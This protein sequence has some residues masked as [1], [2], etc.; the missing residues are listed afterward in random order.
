VASLDSVLQAAPA[1]LNARDE[2]DLQTPLFH[3]AKA[4]QRR[5]V[6]RLLQAGAVAGAC[7]INGW[8]ARTHALF[9][10]MVDMAAELHAAELR[11][12]HADNAAECTTPRSSVVA[13]RAMPLDVTSFIDKQGPSRARGHE[14][15][16]TATEKSFGHEYLRHTCRALVD[17]LA[18]K[19][20]GR[21]DDPAPTDVAA[22]SD[23]AGCDT[24]TDDTEVDAPAEAKAG[25]TGWRSAQHGLGE[26]LRRCRLVVDV[27]RDSPSSTELSPSPPPHAR[28]ILLPLHQEGENVA[29]DLPANMAKAERLRVNFW[30]VSLFD[31]KA[32]MGRGS[33]GNLDWRDTRDQHAECTCELFDPRLHLVG[34][35]HFRYLLVTPFVSDKVSIREGNTYW[36]ARKQVQLPVWGH[37]G[38]GSAKA[39]RVPDLALHR[40]HV[41]E[42]TVL[43]FVTAAS[44]GAEYVEFDVQLTRDEVPV[45]YHN[46]TLEEVVQYPVAVNQ[47]T[48]GQ[49]EAIKEA[50]IKEKL[51]RQARISQ[52]EADKIGP[53]L[54]ATFA[55][56]GGPL[57][58]MP[59]GKKKVASTGGGA[60]GADSSS[61]G[62]GGSESEAGVTSPLSPSDR[63]VAAAMN[64]AG[65]PRLTRS[66][67]NPDL[68]RI[69]VVDE[70]RDNHRYVR[71][72]MA[73]L[74]KAL[75]EVPGSVGFN[76]EIKYPLLESQQMHSFTPADM[77]TFLD[78]T[79]E[80]VYDCAGSRNIVFSSFH[81]DIC[82]MMALK[83]PNYPVLFLTSAGYDEVYADTRANSL[84]AALRFA[85]T[86][87]LLGI[88][89]N[90]RPFVQCP[91]LVREVKAAGLLLLTWGVDN[92]NIDAVRLQEAC[93]VDAVI[94][95]HVA[96]VRKGLTPRE[97]VL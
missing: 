4:G 38:S 48:L 67:S 28:Y 21:V 27:V 8:T 43:S 49:F 91:E 34:R 39:A 5:A 65:R 46:W 54:P 37:R 51:F 17:L 13:D 89:S 58:K 60:H 79:L 3:A 47:L 73:T 90:A 41:Q 68:S 19:V 20:N 40:T 10:G 78:R 45:I 22:S 36:F 74:R 80:V 75:L 52:R 61:N 31:N 70:I 44:L 56:G 25:P 86:N 88:V 85:T 11:A 64:A 14:K 16:V 69:S 94:T 96:H 77:N 71:A 92:N 15:T 59:G 32:I 30:L 97:H 66:T 2:L 42:N 1:L 72:P 24:P 81:P 55:G 18:I 9:R 76:I 83:Q 62:G 12:Y 82:R 23:G 63:D 84:R 33:L 26:G 87:S 6:H 50:Q 29:I 7:D 93:G 95:D 53:R 57:L 35:L